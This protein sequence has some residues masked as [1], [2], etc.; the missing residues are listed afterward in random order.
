MAANEQSE[1]VWPFYGKLVLFGYILGNITISIASV[2]FVRLMTGTFDVEYMYHEFRIMYVRRRVVLEIVHL[3]STS[4]FLCLQCAME[5]K[6]VDGIFCRGFLQYL[7][8]WRVFAL[9][10]ND[11]IAFRIDLLASSGLLQNVR[12]YVAPTRSAGQ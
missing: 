4:L 3:I 6:G 5:S 7:H 12:A 8:R 10:R 9:Q 11:F 2:I 1:W